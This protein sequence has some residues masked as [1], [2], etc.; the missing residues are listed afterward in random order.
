[1]RAMRVVLKTALALGALFVFAA[2]LHVATSGVE[3]PEGPASR[4]VIEAG[5][6]EVG[7]LEVT[8]VDQSRTT[9][10]NNDFAGL[11]ERRLACTIWF[12]AGE[13]GRVARGGR[14]RGGFPLIVYSHGFASMRS[15]GRYLARHFASHGYVF[16]AAD[17]P[18]TGRGS[19]GGPRFDDVVRQPED[20]RFLI[21]R[22]LG[23]SADAAHDFSGAVDG[24]RIGA[25]GLSLGGMTS[26]LAAFHPDLRDPRIDAVVS[27]AGPTVIF[28]STFFETADVPF[29]MIASDNDAV[30][31]YEANAA[32]LL[33]RAQGAGLVTLRAGSHIGYAEIARYVFRWARN[34]DAFAC[35]A[36]TG[37]LP[38]G[39]DE[40]AL[41]GLG[42]LDEG[43]DRSRG[44][45]FCD[46]PPTTRSMRPA[47][48][49]MLA[50]LAAFSF[51][52]SRFAED[53]AERRRAARYLATTLAEENGDAAVRLPS[54]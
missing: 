54:S 12:P 47:R 17:Y 41:A 49:Q 5:P 46:P 30:V 22:L 38:D 34:G 40:D 50:T 3:V 52:Q 42:G 18:L 23:W 13:D 25:M 33:E 2:G 44:G 8:L 9:R 15:D 6:F 20:V 24:G 19:P 4:A 21:D 48:Q 32:S 16:L 43:V 53:A 11:D 27:I 51:F 36:L 14:P 29:L 28:T 1:M 10:P 39:V 26:T 37:R 45:S 35:R 7:T 31:D